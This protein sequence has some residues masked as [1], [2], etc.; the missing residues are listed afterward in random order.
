M[1]PVYETVSWLGA[2]SE[3]NAVR[4][5]LLGVRRAAVTVTGDTRHDQVLERI[6]NLQQIR[7]LLRGS[8]GKKTLV[9]GSTDERD[10]RLLLHSFLQ[11]YESCPN[12][13]RLILVPHE[14][15]AT[16]IGSVLA[17]ARG[18]GIDA[19]LWDRGMPDPGTPCIVVGTMGLLADIYA[20]GDIAYVGGGFTRGGLHAVV[21]PAAFSVPVIVGPFYHE[22]SDACLMVRAGGVAALPG[23]G[24]QEQLSHLWLEWLD[25]PG[26]R[27]QAGFR[28]RETLA[29]GAAR[30]TTKELVRLLEG[31]ENAA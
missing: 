26:M 7:P 4:W 8:Q 11:V 21:E 25:K 27:V 30:A 3:G 24:T 18:I 15:S 1:R 19:K 17:R 14:N 2:A 5:S 20:V 13:S 22:S 31:W 6:V 9:A 29:Q 28:A 23:S 12:E 10:E 16:R